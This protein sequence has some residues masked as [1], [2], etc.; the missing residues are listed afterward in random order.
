MIHGVGA[1]TPTQVLIFATAAGVGGR[2]GGVFVL[3]AFIVGLLTSN[4]LITI[5]SAM[6]FLRASRNFAV[7]A[8]VAVL[9]AVFSLVIGVLFVLGQETFLPA[10]F[11]G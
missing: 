10:L 9:T 5:G 2:L 11:G 7:Y 1:E 4:S 6:G 3:L 8:A